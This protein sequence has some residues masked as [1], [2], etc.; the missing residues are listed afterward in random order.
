MESQSASLQEK[1]DYSDRS[2]PLTEK[3]YRS[4]IENYFGPGNHGIDFW[5]S[6]RKERPGDRPGRRRKRRPAPEP[7]P[8][9]EVVPEPARGPE[10]A[11]EV[12]AVPAP[13]PTP[14]PEVVPEPA[15]EPT[16]APEVVAEVKEKPASNGVADTSDQNPRQ[17]KVS[18]YSSSGKKKPAGSQSGGFTGFLSS[19]VKRKK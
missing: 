2:V 18:V 8:A 9:P 6:E 19:L 3:V 7:T 17:I 14:A 1:T 5:D 16:P 11:P 10:P 4:A 13:E 12:V 15:P